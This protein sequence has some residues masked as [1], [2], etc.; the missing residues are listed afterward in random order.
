MALTDQRLPLG[1]GGQPYG[2]AG[3][4]LGLAPETYLRRNV[5]TIFTLAD[6]DHRIPGQ[7]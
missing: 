3:A 1:H 5:P 4:R 6:P 2:G 7:M